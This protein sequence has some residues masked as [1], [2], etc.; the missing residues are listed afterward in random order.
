[1]SD[2]RR[3]E[4]VKQGK[5]RR[6]RLV[7]VV[8]EDG[9]EAIALHAEAAQQGG[10]YTGA[11][12]TEEQLATA[13]DAS[14][15]LQAREAAWRLIEHRPRSRVE[16]LRGMAR[17]GIPPEI[18]EQ[19]VAALEAGGYI[20]DET[21]ARQLAEEGRRH[22]DGSRRVEAR[23]RQRGVAAETARSAAAEGRTTEAD[24][25]AART[26]LERWNRRSSPADTTKR[27][28]AAARFLAARGYD[29]DVV[30]RVVAQ[31]LKGAGDDSPE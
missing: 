18:A 13:A 19:T 1:M 11:M 21:Y 24:A 22:G 20:N 5:G 6:S 27:R 8:F 23:L 29:A 2:S 9:G 25:A 10:I 15:R 26:L 30:W 28:M 17:R 7:D 31:V 3:I 12:V 4:S 16:L 14:M